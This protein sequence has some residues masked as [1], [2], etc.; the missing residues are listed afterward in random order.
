V[1][2]PTTTHISPQFHAAFDD[3]FTTVHAAPS[4][5]PDGFYEQLYNKAAWF[6]HDHYS[7]IQDLHFFQS[8]W[9]NP[10]LQKAKPGHNSLR[11]PAHTPAEHQAGDPAELLASDPA[12]YHASQPVEHHAGDPADASRCIFAQHSTDTQLD[13]GGGNR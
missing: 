3:Q 10:P 6:H 9:S 5:L 8:N 13:T 12:K 1:Y 7:D 2:N 4:A 11:H